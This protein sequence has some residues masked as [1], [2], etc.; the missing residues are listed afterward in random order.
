MITRAPGRFRLSCGTASRP[1]ITGI[2]TSRS[3]KSG[4]RE[5]AKATA[6]RPSPAVPT[7]LIIGNSRKI[8]Q[9]ERRATGESSTTNVRTDFSRVSIA[10]SAFARTCAAVL[11]VYVHSAVLQSSNNPAFSKKHPA[12]HSLRLL[13]AKPHTLGGCCSIVSV[14]SHSSQCDWALIQLYSKPFLARAAGRELLADITFSCD[15]DH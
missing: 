1:L 12:L 2:C 8:E 5:E 4:R 9:I 6:S 7:T 11:S 10:F 13:C 3:T 15:L 14:L